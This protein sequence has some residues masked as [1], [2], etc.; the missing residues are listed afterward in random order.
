MFPT[1][2]ADPGQTADHSCQPK[3]GGQEDNSGIKEA[4]SRAELGQVFVSLSR[5]YA[6]QL[7][8]PATNKMT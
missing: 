7:F 3:R 2:E 1:V 4:V 8:H 6:L 5:Q